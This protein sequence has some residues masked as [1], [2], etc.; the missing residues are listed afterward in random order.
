VSNVAFVVVALIIS[1]AVVSI[2]YS[3]TSPGDANRVV[4]ESISSFVL[5]FGGI[6]LLAV[7]IVIIPWVFG[8]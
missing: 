3:L 2:V 5:M 4:R 1:C 7:A 6:L 8:R